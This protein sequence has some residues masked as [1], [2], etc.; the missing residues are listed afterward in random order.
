MPATILSLYAIGTQFHC[1][2]YSMHNDFQ[3]LGCMVTF[4]H[5]LHQLQDITLSLPFAMA[6]S[7]RRPS[8]PLLML[9]VLLPFLVPSFMLFYT[10]MPGRDR[11]T[12]LHRLKPGRALMIPQSLKLGRVTIV[13][14]TAYP[15]RCLPTWMN[16]PMYAWTLNV[17]VLC[18]ALPRN[19]TAIACPAIPR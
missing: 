9:N 4:H 8:L 12:I 2:G 3:G 5:R 14:S 6:S 10:L 13:C 7:L 1:C 11:F 18:R 17:P 16:Q 19:Q 15:V